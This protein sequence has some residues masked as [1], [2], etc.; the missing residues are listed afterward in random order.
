MGMNVADPRDL[1]ILLVE[2]DAGLRKLMQTQLR[3][4]GL[5]SVGLESAEQAIA[6]LA[7]HPTRLMLLDYSLPDKTGEQTIQALQAQGRTP[8]FIVVTGHGSETVAVQMMKLGARDYLVKDSAMIELM[9]TVVRQVLDQLDREY[10]LIEAEEQLRRSEELHRTVLESTPCG[11]VK[12]SPDGRLV[13]ANAE[14]RRMLRISDQRLVGMTAT[15]LQRRTILEDWSPCRNRHHPLMRCLQMREPQSPQRLGLRHED[16]SVSW[17][18]YTA[19]PLLEPR[20]DTLIAAMLSFVDVSRQIDADQ[21]LRATSETL[22][23][24]SRQGAARVRTLQE[25]LDR[26][27]S[28]REYAEL[29]LDAE[30]DLAGLAAGAGS[31]TRESIQEVVVEPLR[32]ALDLFRERMQRQDELRPDHLEPAL[33]LLEQ[34]LAEAT[35]LSDGSIAPPPT[36]PLEAAIRQL[37]ERGVCHPA[38]PPGVPPPA[39]QVECQLSL[40]TL[41]AVIEAT[42][43]TAIRALLDNIY[44][45][46]HAQHAR[47]QVAVLDDTL[48]I[49]VQDW[50]RGFAEKKTSVGARLARIHAQIEALGGEMRMR[51]T[52]GEGVQAFIELPVAEIDF[53]ETA[54]LT[55]LSTFEEFSS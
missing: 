37:V 49:E 33:S 15:D 32:M 28:R 24:E 40:A 21:A 51:S 53:E 27:R 36:S 29:V 11:V 26:E 16:G 6:W 17:A 30:H 8:P 4:L 43:F 39:I 10:R 46:S 52:P 12:V 55:E 18:L 38:L 22:E 13:Y 35:A 34:M 47:V 1:P 19:T 9:P 14:A 50:G 25:R 41:P 3:R 5:E 44:A 45:H 23:K 48:A 54:D 7:E 20:T 42:A 2:D 31:V